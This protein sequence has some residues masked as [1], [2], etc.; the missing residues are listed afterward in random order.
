MKSVCALKVG[1]YTCTGTVYTIVVRVR[2]V[3]EGGA[4]AGAGGECE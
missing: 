4:G 3:N 2:S 1:H